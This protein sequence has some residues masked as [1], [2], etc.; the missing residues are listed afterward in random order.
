[1]FKLPEGFVIERVAGP[2]GVER[3]MLANFDD[4]G[5]LYVADST[6]V[7]LKGAELLKNPPHSI[8]LLEAADGHGLF[9]KSTVFADH[10]VF[11]QGVLWYDGSVFAA[12][13]PNFWRFRDTDGDGSADQRE[14][15]ASGF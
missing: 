10:L 6:G 13:P 9:D 12:S 4:R 7:N 1:D 11:P 15:L 14:I 2:P 8:R 3:P 5:R